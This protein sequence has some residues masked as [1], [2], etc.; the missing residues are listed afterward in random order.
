MSNELITPRALPEPV[1]N[2]GDKNN[3]PDDATESGLASIAEGF[4]A[5]TQKPRQEGGIAPERNDFN[6]FY[7][8]LSLMYVYLQNGGKFT[9]SQQVSDKIGGYPLNAILLNVKSDNNF[10]FL[11][12]TKANNTSNFIN[13]PE[14]IGTDWVELI[15]IGLLSKNNTFTGQNTFKNQIILQSEAL[16]R[17][18]LKFFLQN[19]EMG[20][21][22]YESGSLANIFLK[23]MDAKLLAIGGELDIYSNDKLVAAFYDSDITGK[24]ATIFKGNVEVQDLDNNDYA[25]RVRP[26]AD[27]ATGEL[28]QNGMTIYNREGR[29]IGRL[30]GYENANKANW[31]ICFNTS[32]GDSSH[33]F[34]MDMDGNIVKDGGFDYVTTNYR[35]GTNWYRKWKSGFI[36]QKGE[37]SGSSG[38][39]TVN[40]LTSFSNASTVF[41]SIFHGTNDTNNYIHR[42]CGY[43]ITTTG[44]T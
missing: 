22:G 19:A 11:K 33:Y 41:V 13:N 37:F 42:E 10:Q 8:I 18:L 32:N 1:A 12:S 36:E 26:K 21:I 29:E 23:L 3:I 28:R 14:V 43:S 2:K 24:P 30:Q 15:N 17:T 38:V 5:I 25:I 39:S 34:G 20:S 9:F 27:V 40:F 44:F 6:G 16:S 31:N 4:P 35:N 7:N